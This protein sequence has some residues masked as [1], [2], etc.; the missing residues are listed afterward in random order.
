MKA[1]DLFIRCAPL[2][3]DGLRCRVLV[4]L[5]FCVHLPCVVLVEV[6]S[7]HACRALENEKVDYIFGVPGS[8][9]EICR[10]SQKQSTHLIFRN[11]L[12]YKAQSCCK[13][14]RHHCGVEPACY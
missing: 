5:S 10:Q 4:T 1:S 11:P 2:Q 3:N 14:Q 8:A 13:E 6:N 9:P 7:F 12:L